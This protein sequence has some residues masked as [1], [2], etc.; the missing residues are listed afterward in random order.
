MRGPRGRLV[1]AKVG[2]AGFEPVD[3]LIVLA[4]TERQPLDPTLAREL[5][6]LP[7]EAGTSARDSA[8][9]DELIEDAL[10]EAVFLDQEE[11]EAG[12]RTRFD[13]ALARL[14]RSVED[15]MLILRRRLAELEK[16]KRA[17]W[18]TETGR[19]RSTRAKRQSGR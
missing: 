15:R 4:A 6:Y 13:A 11:V 19:S 10:D 8:V 9:R 1:I 17:R 7:M 16:R 12:E 18:P 5:V 14:E 3:R 2:Y